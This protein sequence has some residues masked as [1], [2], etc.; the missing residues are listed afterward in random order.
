[1][2]NCD[3]TKLR[4]WDPLDDRE[5]VAAGLKVR[6]II[7]DDGR[8]TR[9]EGFGEAQ[10]ALKVAHGRHHE[11]TE[12]VVTTPAVEVD[13][14]TAVIAMTDPVTKGTKSFLVCKKH[15]RSDRSSSWWDW[16]SVRN[17]SGDARCD[18]QRE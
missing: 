14:K 3:P 10:A 2:Q 16:K 8:G 4:L 11:E 7:E 12:A 6:V 13:R 18:Y 5:E 1:M 17:E 9:N 15:A